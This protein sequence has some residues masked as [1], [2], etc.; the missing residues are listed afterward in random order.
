MQ[1]PS[2]GQ[3]DPLEDGTATHSSILAWRNPWTE[4]PGGIQSVGWKESDTTEETVC[5]HAY[6]HTHTH[7]HTLLYGFSHFLIHPSLELSSLFYSFK[8][9][10]I[11]TL[12]H[13]VYT[14]FNIRKPRNLDAPIP[15][16]SIPSNFVIITFLIFMSSTIHMCMCVLV[17]Q[18]C[19]THC[20]P[21]DCSPLGSS[22]HG[23]LQARILEWVAISFSRGSSQP[24][25]QTQVSRIAGRCFII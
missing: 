20:D 12:S 19:S 2:L 25:G 11:P 24:R 5:M 4:K 15:E 21:M 6:T 18:S 22:V 10:W 1:V 16:V 9:H 3:E 14:L 7:T 23:I 13:V 17:A 8:V